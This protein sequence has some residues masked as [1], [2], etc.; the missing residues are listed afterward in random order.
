MSGTE[1]RLQAFQIGTLNGTFRVLLVHKSLSVTPCL[2]SFSLGLFYVVRLYFRPTLRC[3]ADTYKIL[4]HN[5]KSLMVNEL[6]SA[7]A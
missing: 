5:S 2:I 7:A 3:F 6:Q 4:T 1:N